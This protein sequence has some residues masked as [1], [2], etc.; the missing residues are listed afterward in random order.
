[1][2]AS[3]AWRRAGV[4]TYALEGFVPAAGAALDWF[5]RVGALPA[6]PELDALLASAR[7][8]VV[9]VPTL[10]GFGTPSWDAAARGAVFG[11]GLDTTRADLAR[12]VVDGILHQVVDAMEAIGVE[13]LWADGGL[14]RS[15]WIVQRLADLGGVEVRRTPRAD[16]TALGAAT[17]AGLAAGV[18]PGVD[19]L[20][21]IA[22]DLIAEPRPSGRGEER[23]RWALAREVV[24]AWR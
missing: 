18:W 24:A 20:P 15:D 13:S 16:S 4:T 7:G 3:C 10:A 19:A 11:L 23:A 14:S 2:L 12:G 9:C 17:M 1:V 8:G 5:A 21:E 6:G 22:P